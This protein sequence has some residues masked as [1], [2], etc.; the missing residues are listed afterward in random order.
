MS[1]RVPVPNNSDVPLP[2]LGLDPN[3]FRNVEVIPMEKVGPAVKKILDI[4]LNACPTDGQIIQSIHAILGPNPGNAF[5]REIMIRMADER[6]QNLASTHHIGRALRLVHFATGV[7]LKKSDTIIHADSRTPTPDMH[8][9]L[10][11][12]FQ[13]DILAAIQEISETPV[14]PAVLNR[15]KIGNRE[16]KFYT[17]LASGAIHGGTWAWQ[18]DFLGLYKLTGSPPPPAVVYSIFRDVQIERIF[19]VYELLLKT[20]IDPTSLQAVLDLRIAKYLATPSLYSQRLALLNSLDHQ[21]AILSDIPW[22]TMYQRLEKVHPPSPNAEY[23]P[24][25]TDF[26][27]LIKHACTE[28]LLDPENKKDADIVFDFVQTYGMYNIP[29]VLRWHVALSRTRSIA[30]LPEDIKDDIEK[31]LHVKIADLQQKGDITRAIERFRL[32]LQSELLADRIPPEV[33]STELGLDFFLSLKG[34]TEWETDDH[35]RDILQKLATTRKR[36]P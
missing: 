1:E 36:K 28:K 27:P 23:N 16:G 9:Y 20:R 7:A 3:I 26:D 10:L 14:S 19:Q 5:V 33:F 29:T 13:F 18:D 12:T 2:P 35:P 15:I 25:S 22:G 34:V 24:W 6:N 17:H 31:T 8:E 4:F 11:E 30:D 32:H 21:T